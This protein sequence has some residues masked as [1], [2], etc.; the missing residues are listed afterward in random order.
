MTRA[1]D[2]L[3]WASGDPFGPPVAQLL[4]RP[5][6]L[7]PLSVHSQEQLVLR[8]QPSAAHAPSFLYR[9]LR[10]SFPPLAFLLTSC[11]LA[12]QPNLGPS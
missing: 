11:M 10:P 8:M 9:L 3:W 6:L 2:D 12:T 1:P 4:A 7:H 5:L